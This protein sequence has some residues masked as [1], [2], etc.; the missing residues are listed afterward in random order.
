[1]ISKYFIQRPIFAMVISILIV[2]AG[3]VSFFNLPIEQYPN[4][5][6]PQIQITLPYPGASAQ[7]IADT[8]AAPLEDQINGVENMIYMYSESASTGNLTLNVFFEIGSDIDQALNNVQ[9]R[10]DV[11]LSQLPVEAQ[12]EGVLVRKQTPTILLLIAVQAEE[13]R[14]DELYVNNYATIHIADELQRLP[15]IS[16]ATV[17]NAR[18][19]AMRIWLRPDKM[20]QLGITTSDISNAVQAQNA[21]YPIG[22]LGYPPH[23][24]ILH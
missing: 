23:L 18:D 3:A 13:N 7:T 11:A 9:D 6:P 4:I 24:Q 20:A 12:R 21:D 2:L 19:Y 14:F 17:I 22:L 15:G 5:T 8:V 1:M 16:N 10:V